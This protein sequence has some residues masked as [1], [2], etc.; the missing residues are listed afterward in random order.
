[1]K[2]NT[3]IRCFDCM[4]IS[5]PCL[6]GTLPEWLCLPGRPAQAGASSA[7]CCRAHSQPAA[8]TGQTFAVLLLPCRTHRLAAVTAHLA[9]QCLLGSAC[10]WQLCLITLPLDLQLASQKP[11]ILPSGCAGKVLLMLSCPSPAPCR[12]A[13]N[14]CLSQ[15][16][17]PRAGG[18]WH[19]CSIISH[20]EGRHR[21]LPGGACTH[22][23]SFP[24]Y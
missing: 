20:H 7:W 1:M 2:S 3:N 19:V 21:A 23:R 12:A 22:L 10:S 6:A 9:C 11:C 5:V 24:A 17:L 18:L 13:G 15:T 16:C 4:P 8:A 14:V